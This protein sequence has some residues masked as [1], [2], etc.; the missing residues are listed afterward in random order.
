MLGTWFAPFER[1]LAHRQ[2][3]AEKLLAMQ[4]H[5]E[6]AARRGHIVT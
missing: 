6:L 4:S 5:D 3:D 2:A 1:M